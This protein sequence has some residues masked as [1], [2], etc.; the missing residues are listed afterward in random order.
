[1]TDLLPHFAGGIF[2]PAS[3]VGARERRNPSDPTDLIALAPVATTAE[4]DAV[5]GAAVTAFATWRNQSGPARADALYRWGDAI[6]ARGE[7]LAQMIAR[8]VGK[9]ISEAPH[10][11]CEGL[12]FSP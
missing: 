12:R 4:V 9:P 3:A 8:E 6:A 1:M 2:R 7:E 11:S 10:Q 5:V